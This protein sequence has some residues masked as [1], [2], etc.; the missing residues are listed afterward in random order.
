MSHLSEAGKAKSGASLL[1]TVSFS[2][3]GIRE[4]DI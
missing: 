4:E 1:N 2:R 3:A